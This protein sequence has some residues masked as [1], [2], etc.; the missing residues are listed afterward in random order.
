MYHFHLMTECCCVHQLYGLVGQIT[1]FM[2]DGSGHTVFGGL[3][4]SIHSLP[5]PTTRPRAVSQKEN[6]YLQR[7]SGLCSKIL[8][9][10]PANHLQGSVKDSKQHPYLRLTVEAA[11][12]CCIIWP[13]QQSSLRSGFDLL[14]NHLFPRHYS[15]LAAF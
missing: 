8:N 3:Q 1:Q 11:W 15:K 13:K 2:M 9:V 4:S 12:I 10:C 7:T 5:R 14:Q 6:S